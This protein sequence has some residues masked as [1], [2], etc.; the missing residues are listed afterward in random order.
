MCAASSR[1]GGPSR[2]RSNSRDV[3]EK[4]IEA[5]DGA[6]AAKLAPASEKFDD[7]IVVAV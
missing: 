2:K 3:A 4:L 1:K 6:D 7:P 5:Q